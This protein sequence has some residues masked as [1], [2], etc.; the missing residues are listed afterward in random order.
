MMGR[1]YT[2]GNDFSGGNEWRRKIRATPTA[3][4]RVA[5]RFSAMSHRDQSYGSAFHQSQADHLQKAADDLYHAAIRESNRRI[6]ERVAELK[7]KQEDKDEK[8]AKEFKAEAEKAANSWQKWIQDRIAGKPDEKPLSLDTAPKNFPGGQHQWEGLSDQQKAQALVNKG[9]H[10]EMNASM[11]A[12]A[13]KF[14][15]QTRS[16]LQKAQDELAKLNSVR[17]RLTS[18][19]YD[20]AHKKIVEDYAKTK[21]SKAPHEIGGADEFGTEAG[22]KAVQDSRNALEGLHDSQTELLE[23]QKDIQTGMAATLTTISDKLNGGT[24]IVSLDSLQ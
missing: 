23:A 21:E 11:N 17:S 16:T 22:F 10:D 12:A 6:H 2:A 3:A 7:A 24:Q 15:D 20:D 1:V 18:R 4:A 19:E 5:Y 14:V 8:A 13:K 9:I